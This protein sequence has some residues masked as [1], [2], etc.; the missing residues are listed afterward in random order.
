MYVASGQLVG[1][2]INRSPTAYANNPK[3]EK[4]K[5]KYNTDTEMTILKI[6]DAKN[7][8]VGMIRYVVRFTLLYYA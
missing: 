5:Y 6:T 1:A 2:N 4:A 3:S 8:D 7:Y